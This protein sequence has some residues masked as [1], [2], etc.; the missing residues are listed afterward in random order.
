MTT[1]ILAREG[2]DEDSQPI[3]SRPQ[4]SR[5]ATELAAAQ[6]TEAMHPCDLTADA[7][8]EVARNP[9]L[10]EQPNETINIS[11]DDVV[12]KRQKPH[13]RGNAEEEMDESEET[14]RGRFICA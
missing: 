6:I 10:Y 8:A 5:E 14:S 7:R 12:V 1:E 11:L 3:T 2:V 4:W 13:T 9:V